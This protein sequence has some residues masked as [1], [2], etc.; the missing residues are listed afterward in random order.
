MLKGTICRYWPSLW[1][2]STH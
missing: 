2:S 1:N